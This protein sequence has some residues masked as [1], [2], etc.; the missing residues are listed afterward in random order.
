ML[1]RRAVRDPPPQDGGEQGEGAR[2]GEVGMLLQAVQGLLQMQTNV[3]REAA[4]E[5]PSSLDHFLR[6]TPPYFKGEN[7][8]DAADF[9][10]A[11]VE[12]KFRVM[13][14][15]EEEKVKLA[16]YVLQDHAE[17]WWQSMLRTKYADREEFVPW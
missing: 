4:R 10:I 14:C 6:L 9:W 7:G 11:E 16:T 12:K 3:A 8:P 1:P 5:R 15:P 17:H 13:D 2:N